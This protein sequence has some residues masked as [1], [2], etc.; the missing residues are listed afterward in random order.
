MIGFYDGAGYWCFRDLGAFFDHVLRKEYAG[1]R[2]FAHFG[3]RFDIHFLFDYLRAKMPTTDFEFFCSGSAVISFTIKIG[4]L[5]WRF[6]D[7]YRLMPKSLA[8]LTKEFRVEHVKLPFAPLDWKYNRH[9]CIGLHEVLSKFFEEFQICSET[10]ASHSMRI[11]RTH[12]LKTDIPIPGKAVEEFTRLA[13]FGGRC[14]IFRFDEAEVN[15]YDVNSLYPFAMLGPL[16]MEFECWT[17]RL[18]DDDREIGFYEAEVN[19]P[20]NIYVPILPSRLEK[21]YFPTGRWTGHF[22]SIDLRQAIL[23]GASVRII[24]GIVF[25]S[26]PFCREFV[27]TLHSAKQA[28]EE[29]GDFGKRYV[30]KIVCNSWYGKTGQRRVKRSYCLDPGTD[31][32]Y[33]NPDHPL[34][35]PLENSDGICW[36]WSN[37]KS[38][39]IL[40]HIAAAV[41]SRARSIQLEYLR[42]PD[43][44]WYTDTD[45]LFTDSE[46]PASTA[47][48]AMKF[49][50]RGKF[51]AWQL[52]EY[53]FAGEISM[54]G[55]PMTRMNEETGEKERDESLAKAYNEGWELRLPRMAG[56]IES[57]RAGK[58]TVRMVETR[59][60]RR[61]PKEK[62]ARIGNDTR[63][64]NISELV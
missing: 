50:G 24:K 26:E 58:P 16:P 60:A 47:L 62:R 64:W 35:W 38:R 42:A 54:K 33:S 25:K 40:P 57:I 39:H 37:S 1:W 19:Y 14:E 17:R 55:V 5:W 18:P 53:T 31:R 44:I 28:A 48:G 6:A 9:D 10:I 15:K 51:Q 43:R 49:E 23:D 21:L 2:I 13:Y 29:A 30:Y 8:T 3:G 61:T 11:F 46:I 20:D 34:I 63:P 12:F 32:L 45:S 22:S 59:R 56:F 41:T 7:S 36:F 4:D 52:K 27:E